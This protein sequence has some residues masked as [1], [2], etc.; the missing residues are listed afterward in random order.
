MEFLYSFTL[1][2]WAGVPWAGLIRVLVQRHG[3][4]IQ[5]SKTAAKRNYYHSVVS[6]TLLYWA[7]WNIVWR[8][9]KMMITAWF[10]N[11]LS[12]SHRPP[13]TS[14]EDIPHFLLTFLRKLGCFVTPELF[15][16]RRSVFSLRAGSVTSI[17]RDAGVPLMIWLTDYP[18]YPRAAGK[19]T[20]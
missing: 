13:V 15:F 17:I 10:C 5:R 11:S 12:S 6:I 8:T 18:V 9:G 7:G 19:R 2:S 20:F 3:Q 4:Y 16:V 14:C 1:Q